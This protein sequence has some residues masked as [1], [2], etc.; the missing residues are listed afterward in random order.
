M[1]D[2]KTDFERDVEEWIDANGAAE[3]LEYLEIIE[4]DTHQSVR[5][6]PR[7]E[8]DVA[9][10]VFEVT[11]TPSIKEPNVPLYTVFV[12]RVSGIKL[13]EDR[14]LLTTGR[15]SIKLGLNSAMYTMWNVLGKD[16]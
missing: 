6:R 13:T 7:F 2:T 4:T 14:S 12:Y 3:A 10:L 5:F 11:N 8:N 9:P 15:T 16:Y 1:A